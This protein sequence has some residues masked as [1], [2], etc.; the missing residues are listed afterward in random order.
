[1]SP[2]SR[3]PFAF[4]M[5]AGVVTIIWTILL[6]LSVFK[7]QI[8]AGILTL[9]L[10]SAVVFGRE[11]AY[12]TKNNL[13]LIWI[14]FI[15]ESLFWKIVIILALF[16]IFQR[17]LACLKP[18]HPLGDASAFYMVLPKLF[19]YL[20]RL[21]LLGGYG[22]AMTLGLH[23]EL[24]FAALMSMGSDWMAKLFTWYIGMACTLVLAGL[25]GLAGA[26]RRGQWIVVSMM[27]TSSAFTLLIGD[28][29]VDIFAAAMGIAAFFWVFLSGS[30]ADGRP[31]LATGMFTGFAIVAKISYAPSIL[32]SIVL[33]I[34]WQNLI[35]VGR[36]NF[37]ASN[38]KILGVKFLWFALGL[39]LPIAAHLLK[40][41]TLFAEPFAP[42]YFLK[43]NPFE[44]TWTSQTWY[45]PK[46]IK[47]IILTYPL[48]LTF[49]RYPM[50]YG[51]MSATML[52]FIPLVLLVRRSKKFMMRPMF[53]MTVL[54][55]LGL[56]IWK[57]FRPGVF[58]PRYILYTLLLLIPLAAGCAEFVSKNKGEPRWMIELIVGA[59]VVSLCINIHY[60][61]SYDH[62]LVDYITGRTDNATVIGP[63]YKAAEKLNSTAEIGNEI[64]S[65]TYC[66]FWYRSDLLATLSNGRQ[67]VRK[68]FTARNNISSEEAWTFFYKEGFKY[69]LINQTTHGYIHR[70]LNLNKLPEWMEVD[71]IFHEADHKIYCISVKGEKKNEAVGAVKQEFEFDR[72]APR[73][74][75]TPVRENARALGRRAS[76]LTG[77]IKG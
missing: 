40:N 54:G 60:F 26:G 66:S 55:L 4:L 15:D 35:R 10:V 56:L 72:A 61:R 64:A 69:I 5:G 7:L 36:V 62:G 74:R 28:G 21:S 12:G 42:F 45:S 29:K 49:G 20:E 24:H 59:C 76:Q 65:L 41:W 48:A 30:E 57:L 9:C 23:G 51:T 63:A 2:L 11:F 6:S 53:Q 19:A 75:N 13:K 3:L 8:I 46:V 16:M 1:M 25:A 33:I 14:D 77:I 22:R 37:D 71:V 32:T 70:F 38:L 67:L 17:G 44:G 34:L 18:L 58:A 68:F 52:A 39:N 50:Q 73:S 47:K 43:G 31:Q 27:F